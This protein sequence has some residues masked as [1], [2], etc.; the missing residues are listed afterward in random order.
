MLKNYFKVA[1]RNLSRHRVFSF[2]NTFGLSIGI[3]CTVLILLWVQDELN[4]D[5]FNRNADKIYRII[6]HDT[7]GKN[8]RSPAQLGPAAATAITEINN[9]TRIVK[10][11]RL[12][13]KR[14]ANTFYED[15][16]IIVDSQFF[17]MF[18][19]IL[20]KGNPKTI[21]ADPGDIVITE[22]LAKK[23][24]GNNNPVNKTILVDGQNEVKVTGVLKD[25]PRQSHIQFDF[26]MPFSLWEIL[27]SSDVHSWGAF[28]YTTYLQLKKNADI[29]SVS[30][31]INKLASERIPTAVLPFW[32]SFELQPL[33]KCHTDADIS[34]NQYL[35]SFT[36]TEDKDTIYMFILISFFVLFLACINFMNISTARSGTRIKEIGMKKIIGSSRAQLILQFLGEFFLISI[37]AFLFAMVLVELF[38]PYFNQI[39]GKEIVVNHKGNLIPYLLIILLVTLMG[40]FYPAVY[41]SSLN[42]IRILKGQLIGQV[43]TKKIISFLVVFQF[44]VSIILV[45]GTFIVYKQLR[46]IQN[47]KL[48]FQKENIVYMYIDPKV[49]SN[50]N[51]FKGELLK[52]SNILSVTA[53]DCLPTD[54]RRNLTEFY[55]DKKQPGQEVLMELIGVDYQYFDMLN[56]K[57]AEGRNF[58]KEFSTDA[59]AFILNE[60]AVK[61]TGIKSPIGKKLATWNKKG[62][63]VGVIKNTNFKSLHQK[64]NPQV[65]NIMNNPGAE[66]AYT[67]VIL[68][69]INGKAQSD[70]LS[71]I[72]SIWEKI[73]PNSPFEYHFLDQIY[74]K[75]YLAEQRT[76][77]LFNYFSFIAILIACLGLYGLAAFTAEKRKKEIG[78]RKTLGA[79]IKT[80][81][82]MFTND[83]TKLVL[84]SNLIAYPVGYFFMNKWLQNFAYRI[85]ISW[86]IFALAGGLALTIALMTVSFQAIRAATTNPIES[87]RYE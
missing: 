41:L 64:V 22:S 14:A 12:A 15:N 2:I 79:D 11:P 78:I 57:F 48:G 84:I 61:Q 76:R 30:I 59:N 3:T 50:Y 8:S 28:N 77:V 74:E 31:K 23:Y 73:N 7:D 83:F 43:R 85:E 60:E 81:V 34:N 65:Y 54:L 10:L 39:S 55:W 53:K 18:D 87:L 17:K 68:V 62:V 69:K 29:N 86:W 26:V 58:S 20:L 9:Y 6:Q 49:G 71:Y 36:I 80:I 47:K 42:P 5:R 52:N 70:A 51:A 46:F 19:F 75:L 27:S 21:L 13:F 37:I 82:A 32:K 24:F 66:A 44:A 40:G 16:G 67:G 4:F 33:M 1:L 35:G 38:L 56:I 45:A 25:I 63:I 72:K